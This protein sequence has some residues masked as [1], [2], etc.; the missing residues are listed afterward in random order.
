MQSYPVWR[1]PAGDGITPGERDKIDEAVAAAEDLAVALPQVDQA[2]DDA[3]AAAGQ[4][5]GDRAAAEA[6]RAAAEGYATAAAQSAQF[7]DTI[8]LGRAAVADGQQFG[9]RAGGSDGL[10]R[11]TIYRRDSATTQ[12]A[13]VTIVNPSEVDAERDAREALADDVNAFKSALGDSPDAGVDVGN[14]LI[15][16]EGGRVALVQRSDGLDFV[17]SQAL[18]DRLGGG[19][20]GDGGGGVVAPTGGWAGQSVDDVIH[21]TAPAGCGLVDRFRLIGSEWLPTPRVARVICHYGQSNGGVTLMGETAWWST[22]P[23][24]HH[25]LT[26]NDGTGGLGGSRGWMGAV[27]SVTATGLVAS[28]ER[29]GIQS[30]VSAIASRLAVIHEAGAPP[31]NIIRSEARGGMPFVGLAPGEGIWRDSV[32]AHPQCY[33]NLIASI[34]QMV[35]MA[36]AAG[37][38]VPRIYIPFT[39]QEAD[40]NET[41]AAYLA[42]WQGFKAD[43][44]ADLAPLGK[45]VVWLLDQASGTAQGG[46]G[47]AWPNRMSVYDAS[48]ADNVY[49]TLPRYMLP[50]G[51]TTEGGWDNIHHSYKSRILQGEIIAHA[52]AEIEAGRDWRCAWPLSATISGNTVVVTFDSIEPLTLDP[53]FVKVRAN[54]GFGVSGRTV[55]GAAMTGPR[56]VTITCDGTPTAGATL[57]YAYRNTDGQDV[58]DEWAV[59]TGA[60]REVWQMPSRFVSGARLLRPALGF[61]LT[62]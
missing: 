49:M 56:Q 50:M 27:P 53:S 59:S 36:E 60:L 57:T 52:I 41:R 38:T 24:P 55:T 54:M 6:A 3:Q 13:M 35:Q 31:V 15:Q 23:V 10:T 43:V 39:H 51:R 42:N 34:T 22:P 25:S 2:R 48:L 58:E 5:A 7:Y 47:G 21:F 29:T 30:V 18:R 14:A 1:G 40:R 46:F 8:A 16:Y 32:G 62:L 19:G 17:P 61:N 11:P 20:G 26:L 33:V 45:P 12:T 44:E 9:V 37:Y 28:V 4:A